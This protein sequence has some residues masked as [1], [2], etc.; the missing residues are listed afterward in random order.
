MLDLPEADQANMQQEEPGKG[1]GVDDVPDP[2]S[3]PDP[4]L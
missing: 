1:L 3:P 2:P 4:P